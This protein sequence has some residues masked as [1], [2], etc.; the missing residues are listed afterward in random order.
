[1][2]LQSETRKKTY[3]SPRLNHLTPEQANLILIGHASCGNQ[4]A[5]DLL[6]LLYPASEREGQ[7]V[8]ANSE[9]EEPAQIKPAP[10]ELIH[11]ALTALQSAREDF[12][13]FVRGRAESWPNRHG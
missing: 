11:R 2:P 13:R 8:C 9:S 5:K 1:M 4:G 12:R 3:I 6:A 10:Y 7:R